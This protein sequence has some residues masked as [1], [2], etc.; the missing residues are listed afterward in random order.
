VH[1]DGVARIE[2]SGMRVLVPDFASLHPGYGYLRREETNAA[3]G[4]RADIPKSLPVR[5]PSLATA[6][7]D[8]ENV[9]S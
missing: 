8:K 6:I 3:I 7:T 9:L 2:R 4:K 1:D 5:C